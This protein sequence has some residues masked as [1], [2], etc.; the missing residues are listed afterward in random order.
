[1]LTKDNFVV[2]TTKE[3]GRGVDY[4]GLDVAH[5]IVAFDLENLS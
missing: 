4:K 3:G 1:M 5:V 2:V